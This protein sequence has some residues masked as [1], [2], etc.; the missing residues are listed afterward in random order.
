LPFDIATAAAA[1]LGKK[2][3]AILSK[4]KGIKRLA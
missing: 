4:S 3:A 2:D 1:V